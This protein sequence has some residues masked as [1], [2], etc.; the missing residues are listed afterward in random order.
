MST[1]WMT[2]EYLLKQEKI[3]RAETEN[4]YGK[5]REGFCDFALDAVEL[6]IQGTGYLKNIN[7]DS[8]NE[9]GEYKNFN[10]AIRVFSYFHYYRVTLTFLA[11]YKLLL[12]GYYTEAAILLRSIVET[13]VKLKYLYSQKDIELIT[14]AFAGHK[15]WNGKKFNISYENQFDK[16]APGLYRFYRQLCDM[17]HGAISAILLKTDWKSSGLI[18]DEGLLFKDLESSFIVN[19][20]SAYLL[21]HIEFMS[22]VYPEIKDNQ[23]DQYAAQYHKTLTILWS[24]MD[25]VSTKEKNKPWYDAVKNLIKS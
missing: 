16:V 1:N 11:T 9:K 17:A 14:L 15:G 13:F 12:N 2:T 4:F 8:L 7:V 5:N 3:V 18:L 23:P 6:M 22:V 21:A 24:F 20:Y 19:Q 10:D 25:Q